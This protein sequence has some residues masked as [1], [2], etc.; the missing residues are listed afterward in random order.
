MVG[1][2]I[3]NR[4]KPVSSK[5]GPA[6][7]L[8]SINYFDLYYNK[9]TLLSNSHYNSDTEDEEFFENPMVNKTKTCGL[10]NNQD[11]YNNEE[12]YFDAMQDGILNH[13]EQKYQSKFAARL[14]TG[15]TNEYPK[16][17]ARNV[18]QKNGAPNVHLKTDVTNDTKNNMVQRDP[19]T[20]YKQCTIK[21]V[22]TKVGL[23]K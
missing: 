3:S 4:T 14:K 18:R 8:K 6:R 21:M 19:K 11:R 16:K 15:A 7:I 22:K 10:K 13:I 12:A 17:G 20:F 23:V 1:P 2:A 5:S 9:N